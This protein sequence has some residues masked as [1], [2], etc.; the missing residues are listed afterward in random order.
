MPL[1]DWNLKATFDEAYSFGAE[2]DVGHPNTRPEI[3]LHYHRAIK[4]PQARQRATRLAQALG[5]SAP[6]PV[7]VVL[8][9]GF[10]WLPEAFEV[11]HGFT[12]IVGVDIS[13]YIQNNLAGTEEGEIDAEIAAVGLDPNS[14]EGLAIKNKLF[15]GGNRVRASRGVLNSAGRTQQERNAVRNAL[16]LQGNTQPDLILT[17][18]VIESLTDQEFVDESA[19]LRAWTPLIIH[20]VVTTRPGQT[21]G[22]FNWHTLAEWKTLGPL[23]TFV[24][25]TTF[26]VL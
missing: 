22:D 14:G 23:D 8:G 25:E 11:D 5:W 19:R 2:G 21:P 7:M 24:E 17:E 16:G 26:N 10:S 1:K 6:G 3:R 18:S 13:N 4:W 12:H 20:F 9:A 15:D